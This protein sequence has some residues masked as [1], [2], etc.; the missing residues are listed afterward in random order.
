MFGRDERKGTTLTKFH[1][2]YMHLGAL[3]R[4][5]TR[6]R[7]SESQLQPIQGYLDKMGILVRRGI[8]LY[9]CGD[10]SVGKTYTAAVLC[11]EV[12]ARY[13]VASFMTTLSELKEAWIK[14]YDLAPDESFVHRCETVRFL[15]IDDVGREYRAN[16]GFA[17]T[18]FGALLRLRSRKGFTTTLTSNLDPEG[19]SKIYGKAA[20]ELAKECMH[21][22][23]LTGPNIRTQISAKTA[24][25]IEGQ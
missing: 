7:L 13:R 2:D 9:L 21:V 5:A 12:W 6:E 20:A 19:F 4:N 8:G 11:K 25:Y 18:Q 3:H 15:V 16:S 24:G 14:D 17:E 23:E 10:N 22:V 1:L